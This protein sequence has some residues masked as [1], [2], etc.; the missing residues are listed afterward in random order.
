MD[1][2]ALIATDGSL[3]STS[4]SASAIRAIREAAAHVEHMLSRALEPHELTVAHYFVLQ[5]MDEVKDEAMRCNELGKRLIG[6]A[7]DVTRLLDRLVSGG[8]VARYRDEIDRRVVHTSITGL[9]RVVLAAARPDVQRAEESA[10]AE[11]TL[12]SR[13]LLTSL[14]RDVKRRCPGH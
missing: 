8:L 7:P 1:D 13:Q 9:G 10:L 2:T 11:L 12:E 6:P 3:D 14:L 4:D 5:A